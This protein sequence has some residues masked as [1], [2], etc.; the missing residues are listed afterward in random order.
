MKFRNGF[1]SNSSSSSFVIIMTIEQEKEW[2]SKLNKYELQ[3][4]KEGGLNRETKEFNGSK[5]V[6]L[7][8]MTGNYCFYEDFQFD[9][10]KE[11]SKLDEFELEEKYGFDEFE[12]GSAWCNAEEKIP[13]GAINY[14]IDC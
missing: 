5:I 9:I 4:V 13:K 1:V 12:P 10:S 7:G 3:V 14:S 2:L 6:I 11:D 8:G